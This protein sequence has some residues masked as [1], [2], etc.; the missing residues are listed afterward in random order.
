VLGV[1][2]EKGFVHSS[3][4]SGTNLVTETVLTLNSAQIKNPGV[5]SEEKY[6]KNS[7]F[8][9][10]GYAYKGRYLFNSNFRAD[11]SSRFGKD[12]KWGYFPSAS[13]GWR[14]SDETFMDWSRRYLD[15]GKFRI[16]YGAI[17]NDNIGPYNAIQTYVFGS[18]YYNGISGVGPN[19]TF[20]NS[21]LAWESVHQF[22][23]GMD[24]TFLK[25]RISFN[26]DY[27]DKITKNLLYSAPLS[28]NTGFNTV[29]VNVG[30]I[31]NKG[32]EFVLSGYP[33]RNRNLQWNVSYNMSINNNTV[34]ELYGGT[35]LLPGSPN[36]WKVSVGGRLG[37][38]Y[39]YRA[40]GVYAYDQS[41]AWTPDYLHQL[42]PV[43][44]NN[45]F[46]GYSLDGK[47]YTGDVKR[48]Y[49][50]G[51]PSMGGDMI[52]QN[53]NVDSVIDDNDRIILGNAQPKWIAGISNLVTYK[54]FTLSFSFYVSWGGS[55]YN[56]AR[57]QLN[58]NATTNVT[59]E[60][61]Y[62]HGAWWHQGDVTIYPVAKN[63][64]LGNG[65]DGSSL[66]IEDASFIRLRNVRL[67]YDLPKKI[68]S[69]I[70]IDGLS[71]FVFGNNL[72][73][74]TNYTWYDPEIS[75]GSALSPGL[76][77]GRFPRKREFG[78]GINI[79]F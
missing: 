49:T 28:S 34:K 71:V 38:F 27:Y 40:L 60:P 12:N 9:R 3:D 67:S 68:M 39:G 74:W 44:N 47:P 8:A 64:S 55:I 57:A 54:Q 32:V 36:V 10:L 77:S 15:D 24:L 4:L 35:D 59:P 46:S 75:L 51:L 18:N 79:N 14:F 69:K 16:S 48:M 62:I 1:G 76:D 70:K 72:L 73:T 17:G 33:I 6:F 5:T 25:G 61:D 30:A 11:A 52:W 21:T 66:Y 58:L 22:N 29:K 31:E 43:F 37:D 78:G 63:N 50:N 42:T 26:V 65:R 45:V 2:A 53:T 7:V 56:N 23:V 19:T 41:N 13:L 20:G